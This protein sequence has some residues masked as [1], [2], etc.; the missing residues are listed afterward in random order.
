MEHNE[1]LNL[2]KQLRPAYEVAKEKDIRTKI[3]DKIYEECSVEVANVLKDKNVT[4]QQDGWS[5]RQNAPV[6]A[7]SVRTGTRN[8]FI[9]ATATEVNSKTA[10]YCQSLL[11]AEMENVKKNIARSSIV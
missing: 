3:L 1:L 4:I 11:E 10:V 8:Y 5:A 7:H 2:L 9:S 6:I